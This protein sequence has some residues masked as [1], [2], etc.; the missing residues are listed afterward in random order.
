MEN[1]ALNESIYKRRKKCT[2]T[3][4]RRDNSDFWFMHARNNDKA[5]VFFSFKSMCNKWRMGNEYEA[6]W[7]VSPHVLWYRSNFYMTK[8]S[9]WKS[10]IYK[11]CG[12]DQVP[13]HERVLRQLFCPLVYLPNWFRSYPLWFANQT[14]TLSPTPI[15]LKRLRPRRFLLK[16][17][18]LALVFYHHYGWT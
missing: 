17:V 9:L 7:R 18:F 13:F 5:I 15:D 14:F 16:N 8:G 12:I 11:R 6:T 2:R 3:K 4:W 1:R 10:A